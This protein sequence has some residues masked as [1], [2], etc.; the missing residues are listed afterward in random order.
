M[1]EGARGDRAVVDELLN[2]SA[3]VILSAKLHQGFW[4]VPVRR[5]RFGWQCQ[6]CDRYGAG[7]PSRF[8]QPGLAA[9]RFLVGYF[10]GEHEHDL[11]FAGRQRDRRTISQ[12][13]YCSQL[14]VLHQMSPDWSTLDQW[15]WSPEVPGE[16]GDPRRQRVFAR[17]EPRNPASADLIRAISKNLLHNSSC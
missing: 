15:L 17:L 3:A 8:L 16:F 14:E 9:A 4:C 10:L 11:P 1:A 2:D 12:F 13:R 7:G 6:A 5:A